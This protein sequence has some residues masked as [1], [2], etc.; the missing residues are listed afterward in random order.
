MSFSIIKEGILLWNF[1]DFSYK[2]NKE[3]IC[4]QTPS[5]LSDKAGRKYTE[6]KTLIRGRI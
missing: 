3:E 6:C 2:Q 1:F 5:Q 4:E